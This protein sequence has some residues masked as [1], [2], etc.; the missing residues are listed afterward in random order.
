[1]FVSKVVNTQAKVV[2]TT[3]VTNCQWVSSSKSGVAN[4]ELAKNKI[5]IRKETTMAAISLYGLILRQN[6][7]KMNNKPV[8]APICSNRLKASRASSKMSDRNPAQTIIN[9]V[10]IRPT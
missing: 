9:T 7:R 2:T 10:E 1:G 5:A 4:F 3:P 8:P 6:Q